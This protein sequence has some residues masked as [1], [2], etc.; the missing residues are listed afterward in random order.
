MCRLSDRITTRLCTSRSKTF[1]RVL[2]A[3]VQSEKADATQA[4][5][6]MR[7]NWIRAKTYVVRR[8]EL[9]QEAN[10]LT[11]AYAVYAEVEIIGALLSG[12]YWMSGVFPAPRCVLCLFYFF[13]L[14]SVLKLH[15]SLILLAC[16]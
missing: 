3:S 14:H 8:S 2:Q 11:P 12:R 7:V 5:T 1:G 13:V 10:G 9:Q 6:A 16:R 15:L 4:L